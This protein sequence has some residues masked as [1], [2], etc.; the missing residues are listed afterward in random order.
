MASPP[1]SPP[2]LSTQTAFGNILSTCRS[3]QSL[4]ALP[5]EPSTP[6]AST[7]TTLPTPP[8]SHA[9]PPPMKLRL[10]PRAREEAERVP[11]MRVVKRVR[12]A[13]RRR[14]EEDEREED[15]SEVDNSVEA[16]GG[17]EGPQTP[18][19]GRIA[20]EVMPLGLA[21]GDYHDL[22]LREREPAQGL[23]ISAH[24]DETDDEWTAEDDRILVELVLEKLK[25]SKSDWQDCARSLGRDRHGVGRRW[26]SLMASGEIGLKTRS[27][28]RAR[29]HSTWR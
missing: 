5:D 8:M 23:G 19:T 22:H 9:E 25:L 1:A 28:R 26:K 4:I 2:A 16:E 7:A 11:K 29:L 18:K 17:Q 15:E 24:D 20:P 3:L 13:K 10:R 21:R 12:G 27:S 6:P 14:V